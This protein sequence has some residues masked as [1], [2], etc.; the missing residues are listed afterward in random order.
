MTCTPRLDRLIQL[1]DAGSTS[2]VRLT[3]A[4]QLGAI[5]GARVSHPSTDSHGRAEIKSE[6][7]T[8]I[9]GD[10]LWRGVEGEWNEVVGLVARVRFAS[11]RFGLVC[12]A[13]A[14]C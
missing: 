3:A 7:T 4:R 5:A 6:D 1:L 2:S 8:V 9:T 10:S 11:S 12:N 14:R 13:A